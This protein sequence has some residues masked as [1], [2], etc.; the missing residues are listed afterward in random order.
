MGF[1]NPGLLWFALGGAIPIL[2]HLLHRQKFRRVRWAAMEFLLA[3][4]RKNQRRLRLENLLL[5]LVR[6]LVM[7]LLALAVARPFFREA[8]VEALADTDIHH[9][10]VVDTS[11]SMAYK[12]AQNTSLDVARRAAL[13][14]LEDIRPSEQ[15][16]FTL[17]PM[18][19]Y[20]EPVL[21][22]ANRKE[23]L[24]AALNELRPS[25][26]ASGVHATLQALK[27][28]LD[29][30]EVRNR[31][32]R[33]YLFTDLQRNGWE[34][35]EEE[36]ARR[37]ADLLKELSRR[38]Y[39]RFFLYDAGTPDAF[40]RAVVDLRASERVL[41]LRRGARFTAEIHN[42]SSIPQPDVKATLYVDDRF[43]KTQSISLPAQATVPVTFEYDGFVEPGSHLVRVS[44]DPDFLD[45]DDHRYLAVDVKNALRGLVV[46]GEPGDSPRQSETYTLVLALDPTGQ[47]LFFS[48][49][50]KTAELFNAEGLDA[51]DFVV[52]AN[53]QSLTSEKVE[54]LEKYVERGGGLLITLGDRVDKVSFNE[55]FWN[56]GRGLSPAALDEVVGE[57]PG[58]GL[59]R[60]T[61]RRIARFADAHPAFRTFQKRARAALYELVFYRFYKVRDFDPDRVLAAFDDNFGSPLLLEKPFGEGKVLLF[62]SSID[63]EW[64][65]G[66]PGHPPYLPLV[67]D[68][69][70]HL[71]SRPGSRRN[72]F[73]GDLL[74][75]DL[76]VELYQPP[77]ILDTPQEGLMTLPAGAPERDQ[78][79]VRLFYP[80]RA[81]TDD[82]RVLRNEGVR[83][84]GRYRLTRQAPKEEERLLAYFA[85]NVP[86]RNPTPEEI[87]AAEG[88]LERISREELQR[89]FPDFKVEFRGEKKEGEQEID[90]A[91]PP[92]SGL[93]KHLLYFVL[94]FLLLESTL[95]W[96]FGRGKQ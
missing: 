11:Y 52:L 46:D 6:I 8:P 30:S 76:P 17:L 85:V 62:T 73:V 84:A 69:C 79:F 71:A 81:R 42:F 48:A 58:P 78:K 82:P 93:W 7:V 32:R 5:L 91:P 40:N 67:W 29:S 49:D 56:G 3:A 66:I 20:P 45:V 44:L 54:R 9:F 43:V 63:D 19:A 86:P 92:A 2:I 53:V 33:V 4:L 37:F 61:E 74:Q 16:R 23:R 18:N 1:F 26:Y 68:I 15:D 70:Q 41:T 80:V 75:F 22:G 24:Q 36:E 87:H 25:D 89:R 31:D 34:F 90:V 72:L 35:R 39:T 47:G 65:F 88:N 21:V 13:K 96:L 83:H 38:E 64:N 10:F 94:G 95:A 50:V 59:E 55:A 28:I 77:F 57:L 27:Q 12:R 60:G 14:V 51:Y